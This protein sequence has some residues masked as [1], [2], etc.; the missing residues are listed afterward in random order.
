VTGNGLY[1]KEGQILETGE[2]IAEYPSDPEWIATNK[3][4]EVPEDIANEYVFSVGPFRFGRGGYYC[5]IWGK[6]INHMNAIDYL[7][8]RGHLINTSHPAQQDYMKITNCVFAVYVNDLILDL[9]VTPRARLF[10]VCASRVIGGV[11]IHARY[12]L[13]CD[14]HWVLAYQRGEWCFNDKCRE[15]L[16]GLLD[17][18][19]RKLKS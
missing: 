4:G 18:V 14:Y 11:E 12:E 1:V 6:D 15:C 19:T 2:F 9:M 5:L 13:R 7:P 3:Q 10:V 16:H 8:K 17:F